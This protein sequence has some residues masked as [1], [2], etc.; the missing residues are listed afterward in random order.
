MHVFTPSRKYC[1]TCEYWS[2]QRCTTDR[3]AYRAAV[4]DLSDT[5]RCYNRDSAYFNHTDRRADN[6]CFRWEKW[7]IL[8]E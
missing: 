5:G 6:Y 7:S 8:R 1:A 4:E 2:G 3:Y